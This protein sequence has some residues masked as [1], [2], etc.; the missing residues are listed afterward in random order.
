MDTNRSHCTLN[1]SR[2]SA[3]LLIPVL[4]SQHRRVH[5]NPPL[6]KLDTSCFS[7]FSPPHIPFDKNS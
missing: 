2:Y 6:S 3:E 7:A 5:L 4:F 1:S